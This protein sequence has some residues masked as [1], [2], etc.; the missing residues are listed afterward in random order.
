ML[1]ATLLSAALLPAWRGVW[2]REHEEVFQ[3]MHASTVAA[4]HIEHAKAEP[5]K[6]H[7]IVEQADRFAKSMVEDRRRNMTRKS[8]EDTYVGT[9]LIEW[10]GE[11]DH[12]WRNWKWAYRKPQ[13]D[14]EIELEAEKELYTDGTGG[15]P[16]MACGGGYGWVEVTGD[17]ETACGYGPVTLNKNSTSFVGAVRSTNNTAEVSAIIF[18]LRHARTLRGCQA[19]RICFDSL[20]AANMTKGTWKPKKGLNERLIQMAKEELRKTKDM[21]QV[22]WRHVKGHSGNKWNDRA[23]ELADLGAESNDVPDSDANNGS[24]G[25]DEPRQPRDTTP[26]LGITT[27]RSEALRIMRSSTMHGTLNTSARRKE[28]DAAQIKNQLEKCRKRLEDGHRRGECST[29]LK[30]MADNKLTSAAMRLQ[31][32]RERRREREL[33]K[34]DKFTTQIVSEI[35]VEGLETLEDRKRQET[36]GGTGSKKTYG[37]TIDAIKKG[38]R[39]AAGGVTAL[40]IDYRHSALG[41]D[42]I[43]AGHVTGSR[44]YAKGVDP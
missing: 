27:D 5:G 1:G 44:E 18:A 37:Q 36:W 16:D 20:Y 9:G 17:V 12:Q 35:D 24:G 40:R 3:V 28:L 8:F 23:D 4:I 34:K 25:E 33:R 14:H 11:K 43:E 19:V 31:D 41:R 39:S 42:L 21:M 29:A 10:A 7:T 22:S 13:N 26:M 30:D 15:K 2:N 38:C 32:P 6:A